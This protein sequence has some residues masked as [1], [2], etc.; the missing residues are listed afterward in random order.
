MIGKCKI[1]RSI[2]RPDIKVRRKKRDVSF[3]Y[4]LQ[5]ESGDQFEVC[6]TFFLTTLDVSRKQV[7]T[8]LSKEFIGSVENDMRGITV[9][10]NRFD[11]KK[12]EKVIEHI[13]MFKTVQ[14]HYVRKE[15]KYQ[16]LPPTLDVATMHRMYIR[17]C[18]ENNIENPLKYEAYL[19]IFHD[20][21]NIK[22]SSDISSFKEVHCYL[23]N[24]E[25]AKKGSNEVASALLLYLKFLQKKGVK[26]VYLFCDRC[27]G[28]NRNRMGIAKTR[29]TVHILL[30][31]KS[32]NG[33]TP[34]PL[35]S[36]NLS[37]YKH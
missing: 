28:Q 20:N 22:F 12:V 32:Q 3:K 1:K 19:S 24:E 36:G 16:Y 7:R 27:A 30:S 4:F 21:F 34:L 23:W 6:Q 11:P 5:K 37:S 8:A 29:M 18:A 13:C 31:K 10:H 14:S 2:L 33:C 26:N 25:E 17:F 35:I 15:S 9:P